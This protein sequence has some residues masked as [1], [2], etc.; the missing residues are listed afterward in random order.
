MFDSIIVITD[1][2]VLDKQL[3]KTLKDL[4]QTDGVVNPVDLTSK[5]LKE[6]LE[7]G[8]D[9][10]ICTIQKFGV[11]SDAMSQLK[12]NTFAVVIDEVHSSQSGENAKE[13]KKVL[14]GN[15]SEDEQDE[16][17]D[18]NLTIEEIIEKEIEARGKQK[19]I[20]FFGYTATPRDKTLQIFGKKTETGSEAHHLYSMEQSIY[21]GF[22]LDV[23]KNYTTYTRYFKLIQTAEDP[24]LDKKKVMRA[25]FNYVDSHPK[26]ISQKVSIIL[27]HFV[28]KGSKEIIGK[29]RG[30][31]VVR[32][33]R[34][35]V[36]FHQEMKK[37]MK[38][39][40]LTYSCLVAFSG[41][42]KHNNKDNTELSL[43]QE[44]GVEGNDIP[45]AL[46][47]PRYRIV[48][49]SSKLQTGFDE[50][51]L[52]SMYI[53][54]KLGGIQCVQTLSRLNRTKTGKTGT[55]ILDFVNDTEDIVNAFNRYY[56]STE[57][58]GEVNPD[59][60]YQLVYKIEKYNVYTQDHVNRFCREFYKK[61][62]TDQT[63][64][65]I[66]NEVVENWKK[67]STDNDTSEQSQDNFRS[68]IQSFC[69]K[70]SFL[71]QIITFKEI[72]W[73]KLYVFFKYLNRKLYTKESE[74]LQI[75]DYI[76]LDSLRLQYISD[77]KLSLQGGGTLNV[78]QD[79]SGVKKGEDPITLSTIIREVNEIYGIKL[80][81]EDKL[82]LENIERR[83]SLNDELLS[84][85]NGNNSEDAKK[86]HFIKLVKESFL[87][88]Y[89][90]RI[91]FYKKVMNPNI[92]PKLLDGMYKDYRNGLLK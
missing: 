88:Y 63:L 24:Q 78:G 82:D 86:D 42:I 10:I 43:N 13:L 9:I 28:N 3:Q 29:A 27:D 56:R 87:D 37:Q 83:L 17:D 89:A 92:L 44:N 23:L 31:V 38:E 2:K 16:E 39:R 51:L 54:K 62:D 85:M 50:P 41:K 84:V 33:R 46:K 73:E 48:I 77:S 81:E 45:T 58:V 34:H 60:L 68:D 80:T 36:L 40:N 7:K 71:S 76:S 65:T 35:C 72:E 64:Q 52:Y 15:K 18:D 66:L 49:V 30:M 25:I 19:H 75:S 53:D 74:E 55:F 5:Q 32:S 12:G 8:K 4:Q 67:L 57:L 79:G 6:Y 47:D 11:I 22:T 91:D 59:D 21:E 61:T 70:Y 26:V 90:D 14:S 20:S 69:R 1:R